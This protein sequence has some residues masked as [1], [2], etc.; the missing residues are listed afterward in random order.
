VVVCVLLTGGF[1]VPL[2]PLVEEEGK[3]S[4]APLQIAAMGSKSGVT[5]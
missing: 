4:E 5:G 1:H 2:I 3:E